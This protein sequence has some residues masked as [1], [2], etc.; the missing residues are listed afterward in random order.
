MRAGPVPIE[1]AI[2]IATQLT[3]ALRACHKKGV[4]HRDVKP[5]NVMID[6]EAGGTVK[7][8]DFGLA[9]I[10]AR[11]L[12]RKQGPEDEASTLQNLTLHGLVFGT[13]A[14]MAPETAKGM[15][16]VDERSDLYALG[17]LLYE[18]MTGVHPFSAEDPVDLFLQHRLT[19]PPSMRERAPAV[20]VPASLEAIVMRLMAKRPEERFPD[21]GAVLAALRNLSV[22]DEQRT[23]PEMM[24]PLVSVLPRTEPPPAGVPRAPQPPP[25]DRGAWAVGLAALAVVLFAVGL[26]SRRDAPEAPPPSIARALRAPAVAAHEPG[27]TPEQI[28]LAARFRDSA[29]REQWR[30]ASSALRAL[31]DADPSFLKRDDDKRRARQVA[32]RAA[33]AEQPGTIEIYDALAERSG[34]AGLEVLYEIV[35]SQGGSRGAALAWERLKEPGIRSRLSPALAVAIDLRLASCADKPDYF[36][37]AGRDGDVRARRVLGILASPRCQS[38]RG[39]C[40]YPKH[41]ALEAAINAIEARR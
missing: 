38:H 19:I 22:A 4:V 17:V 31:L 16:A 12:G 37:R 7:L 10:P 15:A 29:D 6:E 5:L 1:R 11:T 8:I 25:R 27:P 32:L 41:D 36:E 28:T 23:R 26:A 21:A 39:E 40:C 13:V 3:E 9:R 34:P 2:A 18:L 33:F 30:A 20:V 14:Y 24:T 35:E